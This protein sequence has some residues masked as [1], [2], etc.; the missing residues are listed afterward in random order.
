MRRADKKDLVQFANEIKKKNGLVQTAIKYKKE[1]GLMEETMNIMNAHLNAS[2]NEKILDY[3][4]EFDYKTRIS[5]RK[6]QLDKLMDYEGLKKRLE[7]LIEKNDSIQTEL[8]ELRMQSLNK[9]NYDVDS[10]NKKKENLK[11]VLQTSKDKNKTRNAEVISS[12]RIVKNNLERNTKN[13]VNNDQIKKINYQKIVNDKMDAILKDIKKKENTIEND[14]INNRIMIEAFF[15]NKRQNELENFIH[16]SKKEIENLEENVTSIRLELKKTIEKTEIKHHNEESIY[17]SQILE[18]DN[19]I[20]FLESNKNYKKLKK[21]EMDLQEE[22]RALYRKTLEYKEAEKSSNQESDS[23]NSIELNI[24]LDNLQKWKIAKKYWK[25][26]IP[27]WKT[28]SED[29]VM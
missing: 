10:L 7:N 18:L 26:S 2:N 22:I 6:E 29:A 20:Y 27:Q 1:K 17:K 4:T 8:F 16:D 3:R 25:N 15:K 12:L 9:F 19:Q 24:N 5:V 28:E 21:I 23:E 14:Y 13:Q 11:N